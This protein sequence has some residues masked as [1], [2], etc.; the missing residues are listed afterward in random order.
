MR[1]SASKISVIL[2]TGH[3]NYSSSWY[4][5]LSYLTLND[6]MTLK[7]GIEVTQDHSNRY[8]SKAWVW[9][10]I[11]TPYKMALSCIICE[12]KW[13]IGR[14]SWFFLG[15]L[16][17]DAPVRGSPSE[18]CHLVWCGKTI[19]NCGATRFWENFKDMYNRLDSIPACDRP[20]DRQKDSLRQH[21]P[22]YAHASRGKNYRSE[23]CQKPHISHI[24]GYV[25]MCVFFVR[26]SHYVNRP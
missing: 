23:N 5:F 17:F 16:A 19:K 9:F 26:I 20:T 14:T 22:R 11:R 1:Y 8:H 21:S 3:C 24:Y 6:I 25:C 18:Y 10:P 7:S 15:P 2:K 4:R 13:D 12:I